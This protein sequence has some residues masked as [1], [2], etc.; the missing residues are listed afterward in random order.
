MRS[1]IASDAW[2][3]PAAAIR[4]MPLMLQIRTERKRLGSHA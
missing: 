2:M 1:R 3:S 4:I